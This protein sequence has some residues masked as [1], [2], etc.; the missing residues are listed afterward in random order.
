MK[1]NLF[2]STEAL[3]K[4]F[5][6]RIVKILEQSIAENG[7][8]SLIVSGGRTPQALFA[9]LSQT[10]LDWSKVVVSLADERW[11]DTNDD[12]SNEKMVRTHLLKNN[13]AEATFIGLKTD[14]EEAKDGVDSCI[15]HLTQIP[16]PF[17][18][19][20][21]GMGEDGHTASLFPCSAQ[22]G[23]G[24]DRNNQNAY[25]AVQPTT[26]PN[27]RMSLS[28]SALLNSRQVFLHLQGD[29]KKA[30]L[31]QALAGTDEFEMPIRA[32]LNNTDVELMWA[33]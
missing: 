7:R 25:L 30:V 21:L 31:D 3:N 29:K 27:W 4:S 1:Q 16:R 10:D 9:E 11:V 20:I 32:V 22:I 5:A 13:A 28:L 19:V 24:L 12:A 17:D 14:A 33:P 8:A 23:E 18:V 6:E 15:N 26:A 2:S